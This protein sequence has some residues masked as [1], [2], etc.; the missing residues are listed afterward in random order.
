[1]LFTVRFGTGSSDRA[2]SDRLRLVGLDSYDGSIWTTTDLFEPVGSALPPSASGN[3][4]DLANV[5]EK[6]EVSG[7]PGPFLPAAGRPV[8][9]TLGRAAFDPLSGDLMAA[10]PGV[11]PSSYVETSSFDEP[12]DGQLSRALPYTGRGGRELTAVPAGLPPRISNLARQIVGGDDSPIGELRRIESYLRTGYSYD[13]SAPPG[14]SVASVERFL[15]T[16]KSGQ[17]EQFAASFAIL[18]RVL[19]LP[20]RVSVGYLLDSRSEA[21]GLF[22]VTTA[23][24]FTWPEVDFQRYGWVAF[25]PMDP[26]R[27][28]D[29]PLQLARANPSGGT[30]SQPK[31]AGGSRPATKRVGLPEVRTAQ[32]AARSG[33][34]TLILGAAATVALVLL[35]VGLGSGLVV[36]AKGIRRRRRARTPSATGRVFGA[37]SEVC[38]RLTEQGA[39]LA[40]TL[41]A[42]EVA[43]Q[44]P[45]YVGAAASAAIADI[46]PIVG[47][48]TYAPYEPD[49]GMADTAWALEMKARDLIRRDASLAARCR[50][51]VDPRPLRRGSPR[52]DRPAP[53]A[54]TGPVKK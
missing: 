8:R 35:L 53:A 41:T 11:L 25:S 29:S 19:G 43:Q 44:A 33:N 39:V 51:R 1:M 14:S 22:K 47:E 54:H 4:E 31:L 50:A 15:F 42:A 28:V 2:P 3:P 48:T 7:L 21:G 20:A 24:G 23:D 46:A 17:P 40:D 52:R 13:P 6:V 37:W 27:L 26:R 38:D 5:S 9:T 16:T 49:L 32:P 10:G 30:E 36:A 45:R 34:N 18:A 12:T